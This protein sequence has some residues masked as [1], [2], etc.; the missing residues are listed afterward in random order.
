MHGNQAISI[1]VLLSHM[2][3]FSTM[4]SQELARI[5][6]G[7]KEIRAFKNDVLFRK[8]DPCDGFHFIIIGR[9][10][11]VFTTADGVDKVVD[12]L[13]QGQTFGETAMLE[14]QPY[15]IS[16]Q[17]LSDAI[18]LHMSKAVMFEE[19]DRDPRL[20][21]KMVTGMSR[22]LRQVMD[23][24][25]ANSLHSGRQR[26]INYFLLALAKDAPARDAVLQLP[27][28]KVNIASRLNLT[29]EHFS[30]IL[31]ELTRQGLIVVQGSRILIPDLQRL[32]DEAKRPD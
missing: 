8:G 26:V 14:G 1:E 7:T 23:D 21:L 5:A 28:S 32:R 11:L 10:K 6:R 18:L 3:L 15:D 20:R 30:R 12:I 25:E 27:T 9:V 17:A 19:F 31:R 4:G 29:Q 24:V 22:R 2:P 13:G 16:A